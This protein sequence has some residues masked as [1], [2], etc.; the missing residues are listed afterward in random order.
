MTS[1]RPTTPQPQEVKQQA[2]E[3]EAPKLKAETQAEFDKSKF[4]YRLIA[5]VFA[6]QLV[7]LSWAVGN[8]L[9]LGNL[10]MCPELSKRYESTFAVMISTCLALLAPSA[11]G[12][13]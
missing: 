6:W 12:R 3:I 4:L 1:S 10:S 9:A 13:R 11:I 5:G 2:Q 8:C 7:L